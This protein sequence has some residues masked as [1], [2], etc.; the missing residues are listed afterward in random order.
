MVHLPQDGS[1]VYDVSLAAVMVDGDTSVVMTGLTHGN[2]SGAVNGSY[3][4]VA[5]KL[6]A[7]TGTEIW[8]Y[9]VRTRAG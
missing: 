2:F 4:M 7:A 9:Q 1:D 5:I 6:D 8:R 3:D